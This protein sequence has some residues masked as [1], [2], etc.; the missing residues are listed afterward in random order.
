MI[1]IEGP[2][3]RFVLD[4][5]S[6]EP[7]VFVA[8]GDGIAPI[9]SLLEHAVSIDVIESFHLFWSVTEPEG[10]YQAKWCR[11]MKESLDNFA[12]TP[13]VDARADDVLTVIASDRPDPDRRRYYLAG[14]AAQV[15]AVARGLERI[16]VPDEQLLAEELD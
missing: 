9:K 4:E 7:A 8:F 13:L 2:T 3:G 5:E 12:Y 1:T 11:A 14:P 16:G 15:R 6:P 10:Q